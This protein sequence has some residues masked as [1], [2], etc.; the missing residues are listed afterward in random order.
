[1][2]Y[3]NLAAM[4]VGL[5]REPDVGINVVRM[6]SGALP[7]GRWGSL[8]LVGRQKAILKAM[9][10]ED[11]EVPTEVAEELPRGVAVLADDVGRLLLLPYSGEVVACLD[12]ASGRLAYP[13]LLLRR[14]VEDGLRMASVRL[15]PG[16]GVLHL[17]EVSLCMFDEALNFAWRHDADLMGWSIES[18]QERT[19]TLLFSD[20]NGREVREEISLIDGHSRLPGHM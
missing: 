13:L 17:T 6:I 9:M 12:L 7:L 16:W 1:M 2:L 15:V 11:F 18:V 19:V 5:H 14:V 20:W 3:R 4:S 10:S 8:Q